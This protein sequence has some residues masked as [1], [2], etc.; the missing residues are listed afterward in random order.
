[1]SLASV[2]VVQNQPTKSFRPRPSLARD[3]TEHFGGQLEM[4][5]HEGPPL[6]IL[7]EAFAE[8]SNI[9]DT[10]IPQPADCNAAMEMVKRAS[11]V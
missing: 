5:G 7:C 6:Q 10:V 3:I 8:C 9:K 2:Q 4:S 1:M 11:Q